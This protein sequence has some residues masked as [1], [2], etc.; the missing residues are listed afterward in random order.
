[1]KSKV[2]YI[3]IFFILC[4][5]NGCKKNTKK[6]YFENNYSDVITDYEVNKIA[7]RKYDSIPL[8]ERLNRLNLDTLLNDRA[9]YFKAIKIDDSISNSD[10]IKSLNIDLSNL[11]LYK[12]NSSGFVIINDTLFSFVARNVK[13]VEVY[14]QPPYKCD[15]SLYLG[16]LRE[17]NIF[18]IVHGRCE[19]GNEYESYSIIDGSKNF[20]IPLWFNENKKYYAFVQFYQ[21]VGDLDLIIILWEK[22]KDGTFLNIYKKVIYLAGS[23][24]SNDNVGYSISKFKWKNDTFSFVLKEYKDDNTVDVAMIEI[25]IDSM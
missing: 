21:M 5:L 24:K 15:S 11:K 12:T 8:F 20:G 9:I 17:E 7:L 6:V 3:I 16:Y 25:N 14:L 10:E 19:F 22:L 1:M 2:F 18:L 13:K 4:L 23:F